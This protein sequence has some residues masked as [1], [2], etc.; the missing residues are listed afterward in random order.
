MVDYLLF[1][2][3][4][5]EMR[6]VWK[7][8]ELYGGE[9]IDAPQEVADVK[10]AVIADYQAELEKQWID[11]LKSKYPVKVNKKALTKLQ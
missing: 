8:A 7:H 4:Q 10:G 2:A 11:D 6:G 1:G 3:P 5:P 9:M